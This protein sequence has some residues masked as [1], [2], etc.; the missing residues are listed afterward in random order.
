MELNVGISLICPCGHG[1]ACQHI[2][3]TE[4]NMN[5]LTVSPCPECTAE[6]DKRIAELEERIQDH[7]DQ[8]SR[9]EAIQ[10]ARQEGYNEGFRDGGSRSSI[11]GHER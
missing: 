10:I 5:V 11:W 9:T 3:R 8:G 2:N 4:L 6:K 7:I 1:M